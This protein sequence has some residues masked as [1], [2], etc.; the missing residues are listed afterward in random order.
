MNSSHYPFDKGRL[1]AEAAG[2]GFA[3]IGVAD[4]TEV[5]PDAHSLY[6][7]WIARG[8]HGTMDYLDRYH[9]VRRDPRFLLDGAR[10]VVCCAIPYTPPQRQPAGSPR[11]ASYAL[12]QDYHEVVRDMLRRLAAHIDSSCWSQS[13]ACVDTAPLRERY[14]AVR[15]GLGFTGINGQLIVPGIGSQVFLGE[16]VTTAYIQ[17]DAPA[18]GHCRKCRACVKAC[19]GGAIGAD[20]S[21]DAR[22][23]LSYLTIEYRGQLPDGIDPGDRLYGCDT[24]QDVCPHNRDAAPTAIEAFWPSPQ[25]LSA[26]AGTIAALTP[27]TYRSL[28]RHSAVRRAKLPMLLRNLQWIQR[29]RQ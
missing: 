2:I 11:I 1:R 7:S 18:T 15:S 21:F 6:M 28:F 3:A 22:R 27:D 17:P 12:G 4:A 26:T 19:P 10:S 29:H 8:C 20:G 13:R 14:W 25:L 23:C 9:D 16:I 24:C 5:D